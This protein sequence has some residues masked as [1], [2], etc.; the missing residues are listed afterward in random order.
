[1]KR[2]AKHLPHYLSL[3]GIFIFGFLA[4][5]LFSYDQAF[6]MAVIIAVAAAYVAW[7]II[8]HYIHKDLYFVVVIE[9]VAVALLG[10]IIVFSLV[11]NV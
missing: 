4:F 2:I 5:L 8:Y 11:F 1:M 10:L 7:G 3:L 6:Q 9:Y